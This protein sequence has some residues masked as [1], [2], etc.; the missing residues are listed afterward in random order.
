MVFQS[1]ALFPRKSGA[2]NLAF[3]LR[4]RRVS[5]D[6]I[7]CAMTAAHSAPVNSTSLRASGYDRS[8]TGG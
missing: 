4:A 2:E 8:S 3:P 5:K 7:F 6:E 1:Y